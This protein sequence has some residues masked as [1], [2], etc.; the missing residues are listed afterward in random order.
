VQ[1][2]TLLHA[3]L[4]ADGAWHWQQP[5]LQGLPYAKRLELERREHA[6]RRAALAGLAL[7]I[8]GSARTR[9]EGIAVRQLVFAPGRKPRCAG[10]PYFS[11]SHTRGRVACAISETVDPGLDIESVLDA[12]SAEARDQARRW[13]ATEAALKAAGLGLRDAAQVRLDAGLRYAEIASTRYLLQATQL[14][15]GC[16]GHVAVAAELTGLDISAADLDGAATSIAVE[17]S[18]GFA[19]QGE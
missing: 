15:N 10:G 3:P 9:P 7:L 11:I 2:V 4:P 19:L 1:T 13:T 6:D 12:V 18:L 14:G 5:L 16:V 17:R 8:L